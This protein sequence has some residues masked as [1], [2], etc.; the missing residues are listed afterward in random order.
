[1]RTLVWLIS[2]IL[3]TGFAMAQSSLR[4][5]P[6]PNSS[7]LARF[8]EIPVDK[9]T[10]VTDITVPLVEVKG[11][12]LAY[13]VSLNYHASGIKVNDVASW[14]GLGWA[15]NGGGEITR[16]M[17][18]R[19]DEETSVGY[20]SFASATPSYSSLTLTQKDEF[21]N[22]VTDLQPDIFYYNF[23][24]SSGKFIF[25]SQLIPRSI[26][27]QDI[28]ISVNSTSTL[29]TF[30]ITAADGTVFEFN[31]S[32][33]TRIFIHATEPV[34][35]KSTWHLSRIVSFDRQ[36]TISFT[37]SDPFPIT[38]PADENHFIRYY[39]SVPAGASKTNNSTED[40][41]EIKVVSV[42]GQSVLKSIVSPLMKVEIETGSR[43][44]VTVDKRIT[45]LI[46][47][48]K[49]PLGGG[50]T[51]E[52]KINF[53]H[54]YFEV[55]NN[56][57]PQ[58]AYKNR[59]RLDAIQE[60]APNQVLYPKTKFNYDLR[61]LKS[62]TSYNSFSQDYW[63]Y[64]NNINNNSN[65]PGG[66]NSREPNAEAVK[67]FALSEIIYPLG[68]YTQY[69]YEANQYDDNGVTK[70]G[71]GIRIK[72]IIQ[73]DPYTVIIATTNYE[74]APGTLL[75]QLPV[76]E[77]NLLV[78]DGIYVYNVIEY[79]SRPTGVGSFSAPPLVYSQVTEYTMND[80]NFSGK[81]VSVYNIDASSA[82]TGSI[83]M[84]T[85]E[86]SAWAA[87]KLMEET[88]YKVVNNISTPVSKTS[89][90]Y[91]MAAT[92]YTIAGLKVDYT[93]LI[94]GGATLASDDFIPTGITHHSIFQ[95]LRESNNYFYQP[96]G[97][98]A[99]QTKQFFYDQSNVH[100]QITKMSTSTSESDVT[101]QAE[102]KYAPDYTS[103][104]AV[105][106]AMTSLRMFKN[107]LEVTTKS[108]QGSN[109]YVIGYNKTDFFQ[110]SAQS[111]YPQ[112]LYVSKLPTYLA[113]TTFQANPASYLK[114]TM[115][116]NQYTSSGFL[117][118]AES[119][120][121]PSSASIQ[122][123]SVGLVTAQAS[124]AKS[125]QIA[126]TSFESADPGQWSIN[127][128]TETRIQT[129]N[130]YQNGGSVPFDTDL[131]QTVTFTYS[132]TRTAGDVPILTVTEVGGTPTEK[133]LTGSSGSGTVT[134]TPGSWTVLLTYGT[135]VSAISVSFPYQY[136]YK[137]PLTLSNNAKTGTSSVIFDN[138]L[139]ITKTNLLAGDYMISYFQKTGIATVS[140]TGTATVT[141]TQTG[142]ADSDGWTL[143]K[144]TIHINSTT[145]GLSVSG[146]GFS[147]DELRLHPI[148]AR[149]TT[150]CYDGL[151]R[152]NTQTDQNMRSHFVEYD[153]W[154]RQV[155][156][157]DHDKYIVQTIEYKLADN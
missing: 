128:T 16:V 145:D 134:L 2:F 28:Q 114:R 31:A 40:V 148:D 100:L 76:Y 50:W 107:P 75:Q 14:A 53:I 147:L 124:P 18:G 84:T 154:G 22:N 156:R 133:L 69:E 7:A 150:V 157:R 98:F 136:T 5:S 101:L 110:W 61:L 151:R 102:Y 37:Y 15:F 113:A 11:R 143:I 35:Y 105:Q 66:G 71:P 41:T 127:Q 108:I 24:G 129:L 32:E 54:S 94:L 43:L 26:P 49:D 82:D 116:F 146:S 1:M 83:P 17:R 3:I 117:L 88:A 27:R 9:Y 70:I 12:K 4:I 10:G 45:R 25:D 103:P 79:Y 64:Y 112:Y 68:G 67:A 140:V 106:T 153:V 19:P 60:E 81:I 92:Y 138:G 86:E 89:Y 52:K 109:T 80:Q 29:D 8:A 51:E 104:N 130:L 120:G 115:K 142:I 13:P 99:S 58:D 33:T 30:T 72:K 155:V 139:S 90:K 34:L 123:T 97:T 78:K 77:R 93:K 137:Y 23:A 91:G 39:Y 20:F 125:S 121:G 122:D 59:L 85:W 152:V 55:N 62:E 126:F 141:G 63:G 87:G 95:Y 36:D 73:S 44:D 47:Y 46:L 131:N 135:N 118:E 144:K 132:V 42:L 119:E 74:Y 6:S 96:D 38:Y 65:I 56:P 57:A 21:A 111:I 48:Q 149:M